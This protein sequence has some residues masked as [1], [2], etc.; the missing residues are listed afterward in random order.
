M[1]AMS[2]F[3]PRQRWPDAETQATSWPAADAWDVFI[4]ATGRTLSA[5]T[6]GRLK[7]RHLDVEPY[8][9]GY[10]MGFSVHG[11]EVAEATRT[12]LG[13]WW[14][15]VEAAGLPAWE[16]RQLTVRRRAGP[17]QHVDDG[18]LRVVENDSPGVGG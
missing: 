9:D 6:I 18:R 15:V 14:H 4:D 8:E 16:P 12:A 5:K 17:R 1:C 3:D 7:Q 11:A 2:V 13:H 10:V